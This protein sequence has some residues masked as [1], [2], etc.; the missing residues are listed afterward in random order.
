MR[1]VLRQLF[2]DVLRELDPA[3]LVERALHAHTGLFAA[4]PRLR[5][6]AFGKAARAMATAA[7][8]AFAGTL[9]KA[10]IDGLVV[11]PEPDDAPLPPFESIAAGH[12]LPTA[13]SFRAGR[14]ALELC[15]TAGPDTGVL[16]L[17]SGGASSLCELPLDERATLAE[18]QAMGEGLVGSG[19]GIESINALRKLVSAIKGGR[20]AAAA[21]GARVRLTLAVADVPNNDLDAIGS[22]PTIGGRDEAAV[23]LQRAREAD[24]LRFVP[25]SLRTRLERGELEAPVLRHDRRLRDTHAEILLGN[26]AALL[27]ALRRCQSA[28]LRCV[29]ERA[30]DELPYERAAQLLLARLEGEA[31]RSSVPVAVIAGGEVRVALPERPGCGGRNL[32]FAL[33]CARRVEGRPIAVL[34]AGTDGVDGSAPAAG[35]AIDGSTAARARAHGFDPDAALRAFAAFPPLHAIGDA[36]ATGRT[37]TNVRDLRV[38]VHSGAV[39]CPA[40]NRTQHP[41]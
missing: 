29:I 1:E 11:A 16:F 2:A 17:V 34:S 38:L 27:A 12:P 24:L 6:L 4:T 22:G 21:A 37:G 39:A 36:I 10:A 32:Q 41:A 15:R 19:Q 35:A 33:A 28:G 23:L 30:A 7:A 31:A 14:R 9:P 3:P 8:A 20:L 13:G 5:V 18:W 26:D 40:E 25:E